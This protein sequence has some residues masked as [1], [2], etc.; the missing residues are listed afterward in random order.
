MKI[1]CIPL[2][3]LH[4]WNI[5]TDLVLQ[6]LAFD[7]NHSMVSNNIITSQQSSAWKIITNN[8]ATAWQILY[9]NAKFKTWNQ[10]WNL[11]QLFNNLYVFKTHV[12]K[13]QRSPTSEFPNIWL[14]G[15]NWQPFPTFTVDPTVQKG[16]IE[17][18]WSQKHHSQNHTISFISK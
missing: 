10:K 5:E 11:Y 4:K 14:P 1:L 18:P 15:Y 12:I 3:L 13:T 16:P 6:V 17:I 9:H 2:T 7:T 8:G